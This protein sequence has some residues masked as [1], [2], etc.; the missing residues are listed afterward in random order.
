MKKAGGLELVS[1]LQQCVV[2]PVRRRSTFSALVVYQFIHCVVSIVYS[3]H[4]CTIPISPPTPVQA[5]LGI[6]INFRQI[7]SALVFLVLPVLYNSQDCRKLELNRRIS[8]LSCEDS[9]FHISYSY[10][11]TLFLCTGVVSQSCNYGWMQL[12][13]IFVPC[14]IFSSGSSSFVQFVNRRIS[15]NFEL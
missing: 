14:S 6:V 8:I 13:W 1:R 12:D 11:V 3:T 7:I 9:K 10:S 15:I 5:V 2:L 4:S